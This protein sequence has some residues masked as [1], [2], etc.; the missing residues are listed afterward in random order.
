MSKT[1]FRIAS[2]HKPYS[3]IGN[4]MIRDKRLSFEARGVLIFILSHPE[5]WT[6]S[7]EWLIRNAELGRDRA[8]R[9][10]KELKACGYCQ[11]SQDRNAKGRVTACEYIFT[12]EPGSIEIPL[13]GKPEAAQPDP[14][15]RRPT[16]T[17]QS[18]ETKV[19]KKPAPVVE[20]DPVK[21]RISQD[22]L[23]RIELMGLD[24]DEMIE[25]M[26]KSKDPVRNPNSYLMTIA[27]R[28]ASER[29]GVSEAVVAR[30]ASSDMQTRA[31][32]MVAAVVASTSPKPH[33]AKPSAALLASLGRAA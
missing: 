2:K 28:E 19:N 16:K 5:D 26:G 3:Q 21:R 29:L 9:I 12:D 14:A 11:Q 27:K 22:T 15:I 7:M 6:F 8:Y 1:I 24:P 4:A 25:Q 18:K 33:T 20:P 10:L 30:M 17:V 32:A 31:Q 13:T 23:R